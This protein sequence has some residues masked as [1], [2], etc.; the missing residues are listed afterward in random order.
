MIDID[1][2][3]NEVYQRFANMLIRR[4]QKG[5]LSQE[6]C[7]K[8]LDKLGECKES[9]GEQIDIKFGELRRI[10]TKDRLVHVEDKDYRLI[11]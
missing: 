1:L 7:M 3:M 2:E 11:E 10:L 8:A 9:E 6:T 4:M 5:W